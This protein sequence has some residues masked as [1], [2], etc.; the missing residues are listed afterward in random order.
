M[1]FG[2][3]QGTKVSPWGS[4]DQEEHIG[5]RL[6]YASP[7]GWPANPTLAPTNLKHGGYA[8]QEAAK[9]NLRQVRW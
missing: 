6:G 9:R 5:P 2:A 3:F 1:Q 4:T 8:L 7:E